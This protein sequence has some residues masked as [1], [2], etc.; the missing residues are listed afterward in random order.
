ML[1]WQFLNCTL[2]F[3]K[4]SSRMV[5]IGCFF[6]NVLIKLFSTYSFEVVNYLIDC[7]CQIYSLNF[8]FPVAYHSIIYMMYIL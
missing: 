8:S 2:Q 7:Y 1:D 6:S 5:S 4:R 3:G